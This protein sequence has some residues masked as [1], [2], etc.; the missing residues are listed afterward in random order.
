MEYQEKIAWLRRYRD[1]LRRETVLRN[2]LEQM[3]ERST[4]ISPCMTGMPHGSDGSDSLACAVEGID[5][6][7]ETLACQITQCEEIRQEVETVINQVADAKS[8]E[9]ITYRHVL[10]YK[11]PEVAAEMHYSLEHVQRIHHT[12]IMSLNIISYHTE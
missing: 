7:R 3:Q 6:A 11:W 9:V 2:E 5:E 4:N 1:S 10:G 8:R 12:A